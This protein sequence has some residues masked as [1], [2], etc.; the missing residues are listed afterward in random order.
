MWSEFIRFHGM[1][2]TT[3]QPDL[4]IR[5]NTYIPHVPHFQSLGSA[6]TYVGAYL[7]YHSNITCEAI[8]RND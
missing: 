3:L 5:P 6:R 1:A 8:D 7:R 4:F 2:D